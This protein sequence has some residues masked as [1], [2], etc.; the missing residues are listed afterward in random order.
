MAYPFPF[1]YNQ[2]GVTRRIL[3]HGHY[4]FKHDTELSD[5]AFTVSGHTAPAAVA[6][7]VQSGVVFGS[8]STTDNARIVGIYDSEPIRLSKGYVLTMGFS[9]TLSDATDMDAMLGAV[10]STATDPFATPPT[11]GVYFRKDDDDA[12]W[13]GA[14]RI[15]SAGA[16]LPGLLAATTNRVD[17]AFRVTCDAS[18]DGKGSI[19]FYANNVLVGTASTTT[20]PY[21]EDLAPFLAMQNGA[22]AAKT[23]TVHSVSWLLENPSATY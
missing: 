17:L 16:S 18:T 4:E 22:A 20:L 11:D 9:V 8:G 5:W 13:D 15:N 1:D 3:S 10:I 21:D 19:E 6:D 2:L 23:M 12:L 7:G 14:D